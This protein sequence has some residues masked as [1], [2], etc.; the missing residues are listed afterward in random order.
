[1]RFLRKLCLCTSQRNS[2]CFQ[3]FV[4]FHLLSGIDKIKYRDYNKAF[5]NLFSYVYN[6]YL[7]WTA[8]KAF[9]LESIESDVH[10]GVQM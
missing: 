6:R 5:T 8:L 9:S 3:Y 10:G 7:L 4:K 2:P 1:M